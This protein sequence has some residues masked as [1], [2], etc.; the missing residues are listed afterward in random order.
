MLM[1]NGLLAQRP[2]AQQR[3]LWRRSGAVG[4]QR[5]TGGDAGVP[6]TGAASAA[7]ELRCTATQ[8]AI[9]PRR[10]SIASASSKSK[11]IAT[12]AARWGGYGGKASTLVKPE[13]AP[14][15]AYYN[16]KEYMLNHLRM[17]CAHPR[18][19]GL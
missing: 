11:A 14:E 12:S 13:G 17:F 7:R 19:T 15:G 9:R 5:Q 16:R 10:W 18:R 8:G 1:V 3:H 2:G 4:H 6:I